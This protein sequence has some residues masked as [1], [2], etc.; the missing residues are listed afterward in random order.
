MKK[1][2]RFNTQPT[3]QYETVVDTLKTLDPIEQTPA[4]ADAHAEVLKAEIAISLGRQQRDTKAWFRLIGMPRD[5]DHR[6]PGDDHVELWSSAAGLRYVS[7]PYTLDLDTLRAMVAFADEHGLE[8][9]ISG[10]SWYYPGR[11][12]SILW[13][14]KKS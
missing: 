6:L 10:S 2:S 5:A 4:Y 13:R 1:P 11:T 14:P 8:I 9:S 12:L 7:H 3:R